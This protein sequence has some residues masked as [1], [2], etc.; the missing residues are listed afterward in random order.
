MANAEELINAYVVI[1]DR[2]KELADRH[3]QEMVPFNE[4]LKLLEAGLLSAL[5]DTGGESIK[6][7]SGTAYRI[8]RT[9]VKTDDWE[10]FLAFVLSNDLTHMLVH[11]AAKE[12]VNEYIEANGTAP[13][14][15][16]ISTDNAIGVRRK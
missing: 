2:K 6:S 4:K 12:S 15:L 14:G 8:T 7:K 3:K 10:A 1:R 13:P 9:S 5:N 16:A 11:G